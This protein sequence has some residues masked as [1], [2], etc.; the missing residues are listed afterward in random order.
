MTRNEF[1]AAALEDLPYPNDQVNAAL[2]RAF[3]AN[4][5]QE[6]Y[7]KRD[8]DWLRTDVLF[9]LPDEEFSILVKPD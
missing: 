9:H 6:E 2:R 8:L 4:P 3:D 5:Q 1:I 7:T